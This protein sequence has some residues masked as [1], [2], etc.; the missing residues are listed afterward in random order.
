M[1]LSVF[2]AQEPF[3]VVVALDAQMRIPIHSCPMLQV[4]Y[5]ILHGFALTPPLPILEPTPMIPH[6]Y[7]EYEEAKYYIII[8]E[9]FLVW[10][11]TVSVRVN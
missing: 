10:Y 9:L 5:P 11:I 2:R 4:N 7:R 6:T 3:L 8:M 1:D